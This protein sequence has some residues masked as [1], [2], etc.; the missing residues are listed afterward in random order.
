MAAERRDRITSGAK[1][2]AA[3]AIAAASAALASACR[4]ATADFTW[5]YMRP[6]QLELSVNSI[7]GGRAAVWLEGYVTPNQS[8]TDSAGLAGLEVKVFG[9]RPVYV[10]TAAD[11]IEAPD[12]KIRFDVPSDGEI[13]FQLRLSQDGEEVARGTARWP[14]EPERAWLVKVSRVPAIVPHN[15]S[16]S[17]GDSVGALNCFSIC[18]YTWR[19]PISAE[20]ANY[21]HEGL[22]LT[23]N[24]RGPQ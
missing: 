14:L 7:T 16:A 12:R 1:A 2:L 23:V 10:F 3:L 20:A 5:W 11:F 6:H 13:T 18:A 17:I 24:R 8:L 21:L 19:F 4:D 22:W 9:I 15:E